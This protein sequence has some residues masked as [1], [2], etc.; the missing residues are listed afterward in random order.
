MFGEV[1]RPRESLFAKFALVGLDSGMG[2]LVASKFIGAAE[3]PSASAP[4]AGER[5]LSGMAAKV[6]L[7][8]GRLAVDLIAAGVGAVVD[9]VIQFLRTVQLDGCDPGPG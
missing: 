6:S 2:A 3:A 7:E 8:V 4:G 5:L 1:V 9:L